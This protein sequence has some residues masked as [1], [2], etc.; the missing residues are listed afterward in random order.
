M[1][2]IAPP[3]T[4]FI[5]RGDPDDARRAGLAFGVPLPLAPCRAAQAGDRAALWLGPDEW[6]LLASDGEAAA[7]AA[8]L[9][10]IAP[11]L[12]DISDGQIALL[13]HGPGAARMLSAGCP[14]DLHLSAFPVGMVVRTAMARIGITLWRCGAEEW[15]LETGRSLGAYARDFLVEA[16]K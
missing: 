15:R 12:V 14:L 8:A 16:N 11:S 10:G 2:E 3:A 9:A 5:L 1:V 7:I 4:R 13:L 6:M